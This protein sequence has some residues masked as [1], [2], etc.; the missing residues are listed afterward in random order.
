MG[1]PRRICFFFRTPGPVGARP[2]RAAA[3]GRWPAGSSDHRRDADAAGPGGAAVAPAGAARRAGPPLC[4]GR[5]A[6]GAVSSDHLPGSAS[7]LCEQAGRRLSTPGP[8]ATAPTCA[9]PTRFASTPG[10]QPRPWNCRTV[11]WPAALVHACGQTEGGGA[12]VL[13]IDPPALAPGRP[14]AGRSRLAGAHPPQDPGGV[15][16]L[17]AG[18]G[19]SPPDGGGTAV[20][21]SPAPGRAAALAGRRSG[22]RPGR[23][24]P[25]R[26]SGCWWALTRR[27]IR[28]AG[29][30][31]LAACRF[32][33]VPTPGD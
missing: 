24:N 18:A 16:R 13:M 19:G 15:R 30:G 23:R 2:R 33:S 31:R 1:T 17:P 6:P 20:L 3:A 7:L 14:C 10:G 25:G 5:F 28:P 8:P 21:G 4:A 29:S 26:D 22:A 27:A 9:R 32:R 11:P 12:P